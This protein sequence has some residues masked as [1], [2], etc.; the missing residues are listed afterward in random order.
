MSTSR[1]LVLHESP[2][3]LGS[4]LARFAAVALRPGLGPGSE[5]AVMDILTDGIPAGGPGAD[6]SEYPPLGGPRRLL[7]GDT[8][9]RLSGSG[10][11]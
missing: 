11:F 6:M 10:L 4:V 5:G 8:R 1:C 7:R 9:R 2:F 3:A